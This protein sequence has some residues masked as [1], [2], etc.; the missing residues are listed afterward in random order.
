[1]KI[2]EIRLKMQSE[3][4]VNEIV[5][6]YQPCFDEIDDIITRLKEDNL[7]DEKS[8]LSAQTKLT[9]LYGTLITPFKVAEAT[10]I[11]KEAQNFILI[12]EEYETN[13]PGAKSLAIGKLDQLTAV[14]IADWRTLRNILEGYVLAAEKAIITCQSNLKN[15]KTEKSFSNNNPE[16]Y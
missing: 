2:Q 1:M 16:R 10:K 14:K 7:S 11:H 15:L 8:L 13:N 5:E 12:N 3:D 6:Y 4:G 9:G